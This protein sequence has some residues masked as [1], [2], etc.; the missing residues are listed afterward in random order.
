MSKL[1]IPPEEFIAAVNKRLP[2]IG[3]YETGMR[4][5]LYPEGNNGATASGYSLEPDTIEARAVVGTAVSQVLFEFDI[6]QHLSRT[7]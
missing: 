4:V 3:G 1:M 5:S 2:N 7:A 6:D